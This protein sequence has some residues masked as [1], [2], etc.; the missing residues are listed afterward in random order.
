V[1]DTGVVVKGNRRG[2]TAE[3]TSRNFMDLLL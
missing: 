1:H 2:R 3:P